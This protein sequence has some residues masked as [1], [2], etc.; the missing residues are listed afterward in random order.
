MFKGLFFQDKYMRQD[1]Q[2]YLELLF[3]DATYKLLDLRL[4]FY[5][6]LVEDSN[7]ESEI[8]SV[9]ILTSED[10]ESI[11]WMVDIFKKHNTNCNKT[12]VVMADK[13]IKE[14][15]VVKKCFP[16]ANVLICLFHTLGEKLQ[17]KK[18][19]SHQAKEQLAWKCTKITL[20]YL[21]GRL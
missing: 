15:D 2:A 17:Q 18:W 16:E 4:P 20:C 3:L 10:S 13:D 8:V 1:F 9:C 11:Q 7:G 12:R 14:R 19:V 6:M 5:L 21:P